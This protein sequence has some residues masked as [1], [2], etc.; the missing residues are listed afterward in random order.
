MNIT[1]KFRTSY[2]IKVFQV[3][4]QKCFFFFISNAFRFPALAELPYFVTLY[5]VKVHK[6]Y[7]HTN[8]NIFIEIK[9]YFTKYENVKKKSKTFRIIRIHLLYNPISYT[10]LSKIVPDAGFHY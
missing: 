6:V 7:F 8:N 4:L 3:N 2:W 5:Q 9:I 1:L 10:I